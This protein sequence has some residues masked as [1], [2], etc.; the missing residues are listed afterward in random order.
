MKK[1][2]FI[3]VLGQKIKVVYEDIEDWGNCNIDEKTITLSKKCLKDDLIHRET[4]IHEVIH[5]I[6][7]MT[8]LAYME[9]NDE[10]AY[11]RCIENLIIPWV[12]SF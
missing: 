10:E 4:L 8:G 9:H 3:N 12:L 11:V 2:S 6:L 1:L 7:E 5:M